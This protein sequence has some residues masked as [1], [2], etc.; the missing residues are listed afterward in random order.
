AGRCAACGGWCEMTNAAERPDDTLLSA[1]LDGEVE[2][3]ECARIQAWLQEHPVDASL[4]RLWAADRDALR[5]RFSSVPDEPIP[6]RLTQAVWRRSARRALN[7]GPW[8]QAV[9]AV[10]LLAVG[11]V[12][13][14]WWRGGP[15]AEPASAGSTSWTQR[16]AVAHAVYAPEVRHPV[17]VSVREGDA[18]QQREQ[19]AHLSRWLTR[20]LSVPVKL[21]DLRDQGFE[22]VGGRLLP[23]G[24]GPSAQLMYQ[25]SMGMRVTVYL[26]KAAEQDAPAAFAF[27]RRGDLGMFYWVEGRS[28]YALVGPQSRERLLAL[29]QAIYKQDQAP[30]A[31]APR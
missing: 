6:E 28:G 19:E 25:D 26:R 7:W 17:E 27:E 4:V 2:G 8:P 5:A 22:L 9:A 3:A 16:A 21:F 14:A 23:D 1:W 29:A 30:A 11:V 24:A 31:S 18:A 10:A 20:R 12:I 13:G 15:L